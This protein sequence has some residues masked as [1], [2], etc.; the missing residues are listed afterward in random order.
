MKT[1][2][3]LA[4]G[5]AVGMLAG[6]AG[7]VRLLHSDSAFAQ[8]AVPA[9]TSPAA[10]G[11]GAVGQ[12]QAG[13]AGRGRGG[14]LNFHEP[15]PMAFDDHEGYL[16]LFDGT[17]KDWEGDPKFWRVENGALVGE[18]LPDQRPRNT[19]ISYKGVEARDFDLKLEVKVEKGGGTGIQY[20][21]K[22]GISW[23][24]RMEEGMRLDWL[25]TGP[26]ADFWF[27]VNP[28][29]FVFTG[30]IYS[31]NT[32]LG[33]IAWRGQVVHLA[34]GKA[35]RLV[36]NIGDRSA[37]GGYVKINDWNQYLVIARGG[38]LLH[39]INGQLM[40]V[41]VDDDPKSSM[42]QTGIFGIELEG[43]PSKVSVRNLWLKK[44]S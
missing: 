17:L 35:A 21:S 12:T 8:Q 18:R 24:N 20:R 32:P 11:R 26:Q 27:P 19:F 23:G 38:T 1:T 6:F 29:S 41:L 39:I 36:G 43:Q 10:P 40:A 5:A 33:I 31:E 15:D 44:H 30:Q 2:T 42:N 34:Q 4:A 3:A 37:L 28:R 7:A 22:T 14:G 25:M 13:T 16:S 9:Q